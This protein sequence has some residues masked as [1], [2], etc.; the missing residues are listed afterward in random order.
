M[1]KK[2]IMSLKRI[3]IMTKVVIPF[4]EHINQ[5]SQSFFYRDF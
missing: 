5:K 1:V 3:S 4:Y 2:T